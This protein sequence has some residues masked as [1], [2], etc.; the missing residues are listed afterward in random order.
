MT[1]KRVHLISNAHLDPVWLWQWE[2]GAAAAVSTFR[3]AA[4]LCEEFDGF[5][6]NHNEAVLYQWVEEY[7]PALFERIQRLV[8]EGKW[9][10]M[11]GWHV[12][13]D[14]NMP[15]GESFVRQILVGRK[16]FADKFGVYP[17]TALNFDP[18]GHT[19]GLVQI[20]AKSGYDSYIVCRPGQGDTE[21]PAETFVWVGYDGS[22]VIGRRCSEGYGSALGKVNEKIKSTLDFHPDD[23]PAI[24]LWGVGDHGGGPSHADLTIIA[25]MMKNSE[26]LELIHSTL[27][28]YFSEISKNDLPR[29]SKD[30]NPWAVGCYTSQVRIKQKHRQL[31]NEIYLTEKMMSAASAQGVLKY[32]SNDFKDALYDLLTCEFHDILPGSSVQPS[33]DTSLRMLDHGLE[34]ISR[35]KTRAFFALASGQPVAKEGEI[36]ILVYNPHPFPVHGVYECEFQ[37]ADQNWGDDW[38]LYNVYNGDQLLPSQTIKEDS[39]LSLDWR[40]RVAFVADLEPGKMNRFD[41]K[42]VKVPG[43]P[44]TSTEPIDGHF[45]IKTDDLEATVSAETGLMDMYRIGGTDYVLPGAFL[46]LVIADNEDPW[47]MTVRSFR[48]VAG[49]FRLMTPEESAKFSA[50]RLDKLPP[51]RVIENG[52]A[53]MVVE[54]NFIY[55]HSM[56]CQRYKLPKVSSEVEIETR[57]HWNEKNTML[58]L[59]AQPMIDNAKYVGQ[60]AYGA[61]ELPSNGDEAVAQKWV[62]VV[63]ENGNK[64]LTCINDGIYGSDFS[65]DGLRITL[66]R[67]PAYSGHPI[68]DRQIVPQDQYL[69]RIDQGER[70]FRFWMNAGSVAERLSHIDREALAHNEKPFVVSFFPSG[71][72]TPLKSLANLSDDSIL[73]TAIKMAEDGNGLIIRLFNPADSEAQTTLSLPTADMKIDLKFTPFEI[74][75]LRID[76]AAKSFAEVDLMEKTI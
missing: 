8:K 38:T 37:M 10:I 26:D 73:V 35:V 67:S 63:S 66:L 27:E 25:D 65:E 49:Q 44:Q 45:G 4:D 74:K 61:G 60:V 70:I 22:E 39:N 24:V 69:P 7:E 31:E 23:D 3:V 17:T 16:Y 29:V 54:A 9:H 33:E 68:M 62:A 41:C 19:R 36:P 47:G 32:P 52:P 42:A 75:T 5:I 30:L 56:I 13:P 12:Q 55:N 2:E 6:F 15:G 76:L 18:F 14:C 40:K 1:K 71:A 58:K 46:P 20:L 51:V 57:V 48:N 28:S 59:Q 21:L 34:T 72:G 53:R 64:T 43:K 50:V 11:G